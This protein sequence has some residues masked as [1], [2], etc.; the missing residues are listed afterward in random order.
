MSRCPITYSLIEGSRYSPEGLKLLANGLSDIRPFEYTAEEQRKEAFYRASLMSI[1]GVQPKLSTIFNIKQEKFEITDRG[2]RYILKP[3]HPYFVQMPENEDLSMRLAA[4][5]GLDVPVHGMIW[6]KD[7]TLSYFIKRF[8]RKGQ[9]DKVPMEDF[10]QLAGL[11]RDTKYDS[12][13]EKVVRL[14]DKYCTFPV[15]EKVK[16]F[17]LVLFS[18]IIGNDDMHLKNF[19]IINRD[20][21]IELSPCYDLVNTIIEYRKPEDEIALPLRGNKKNL[22]RNMLVKYFGKERCELTDKVIDKVINTIINAVPKWREEIGISFLSEEMK[23][24][25]MELLDSRLGRL[26]LN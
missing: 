17:K 2:G 16:L 6:A 10:A 7:K 24:K 19:S 8:D 11:S 22:N 25:Y 12:S 21:K 1:Q 9:N 20:G 3:Q 15:I 13:M 14:V 18:F 23:Q 4:E 26:E 5:I